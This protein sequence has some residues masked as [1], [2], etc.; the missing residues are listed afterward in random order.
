MI[1]ATKN[2]VYVIRINYFIKNGVGKRKRQSKIFT[3]RHQMGSERFKCFLENKM[4]QIKGFCGYD[5][6]DI[7]LQYTVPLS[8]FC[9]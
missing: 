7:G 9:K 6:D 2:H 1:D 5:N 4:R 8:D 3:S